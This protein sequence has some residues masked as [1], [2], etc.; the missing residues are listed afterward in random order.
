[1]RTKDWK[2]RLAITVAVGA[3]L[4]TTAYAS[5]S[6]V[7]AVGPVSYSPTVGGPATITVRRLTIDP[8]EVLGW[9]SHPGTVYTV[10]KRGTL[11]LEDGCGGIT[12]F[13]V[14]QGFQEPPGRV[15]RGK[16]LGTD[17]V[18][19]IQTFIVPAGSLISDPSGP[20]CQTCVADSTTFCAN[21]ARYAIRTQWSTQDGRSGAGQ[22][23]NVTGDT[24]AFWFF[25]PG[26]GE[27]VVKVLNG[28]ALNS[29][30]WTFAAGLTDVNV[31]LTVTDT[32]TGTVQTYTHREGTRF[33]PILD[34]NAFAT[35]PTS[36]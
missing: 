20:V 5:V 9:H 16:N 19:T 21:N 18:E 33:D 28:C 23:I 32:Q 1:M 12:T 6:E 25:T 26:N 17:V 11:T 3:F 14:G 35:C 7:I 24:G 15:H 29:R 27:V 2:T 10:V 22:V 34:T 30:Y 4:A 8:G 31:V 36:M 13:T